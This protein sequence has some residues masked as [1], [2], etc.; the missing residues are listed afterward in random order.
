MQQD[1]WAERDMSVFSNN[2]RKGEDERT[3][4]VQLPEDAQLFLNFPIQHN[5]QA[6][7]A[8]TLLLVESL[9]YVHV[10]VMLPAVCFR[11]DLVC[12]LIET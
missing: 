5:K 12:M 8:L 10:S 2:P 9:F 3:Q 6:Q 7:Y 4:T 1:A 11:G